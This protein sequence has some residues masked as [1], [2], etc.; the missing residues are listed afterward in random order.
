MNPT[1]LLYGSVE[2]ENAL[3]HAYVVKEV[4]DRCGLNEKAENLNAHI[5]SARDMRFAIG[6]VGQAKRGKST[7]INAILGR[8]DDTM[9]P[10]DR[11]PATNVVSCFVASPVEDVKVVFDGK[12]I[13]PKPI[14]ASEIKH[15]ACEEFN[16]RNQKGV[17]V[18]EV[19]APFAGLGD[20]V[21][22]VD[23]PGADNAL[24]SV[25]DV[26]L[27]DCLPRLDAVIFLVAA[28]APLTS[29]E[30]ALLKAVR[31]NDVKKLLFAISMVDT[32]E[33]DELL[34]ALSHNQ[35]VLAQVEFASA[36]IFTIS[37]KNYQKN[38]VDDGTERLLHA[39]RDLIGDGRA[40]TIAERLTDIT[41]RTTREAKDEVASELEL[42]LKTIDEVRIEKSEL[43][44]L[45]NKISREG[46]AM[47]REFRS[48]WRD[49]WT[50][51]DDALPGIEKQLRSDYHELVE[52]TSVVKLDALGKTVH[53]DVLK[54]LDEVIEPHAEKL[55]RSLDAAV[56][57]LGIDYGVRFGLAPGDIE[58]I[59]TN[60]DMVMA[61][62]D[63]AAS[64]VPSVV[65]AFVIGSLPGL[66]GSAIAASA[67]TIAAVGWNP[68]TWLP[69]LFTGGAATVTT[70]AAGLATAVLAPLTTVGTPLLIGY[71]GLKV[72]AAY[73]SKSGQA[74]NEISLSLKNMIIDLVSETRRNVVKLKDQDDDILANFNDASS[75]K[76]DEYTRRTDDLLAKRP[77]PEQIRHL[78]ESLE[79]VRKLEAPKA[80]PA[81][82]QTTSTERLF[83]V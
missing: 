25:H 3:K 35:R 39:V 40:K 14:A 29:S 77:N 81:S 54:R 60:K 44:T 21:V 1:A 6:V 80:S 48:K 63:V 45:R 24:S 7:L 79:I 46:P 27:L 38:G 82:N 47:E 76:L 41:E 69:W 13:P 30:L 20:N 4:L 75:A 71:A 22:L 36:P 51:F 31:K 28:H 68:M 49:A 19:K 34:E 74:R 11:F 33:P 62:I 32:V 59:T 57:E 37:A 52:Q 23:T 43:E 10:V 58:A 42:S 53:S 56:R 83:D 70:G 73:R 26:V 65:G 50:E 55:R 64:G 16:P 5:E 67:P 78:T 15:Y 2:L 8:S 17:K 9:A 61:S 66:V 12:G 72:I 18:I